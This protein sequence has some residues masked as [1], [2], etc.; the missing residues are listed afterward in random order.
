MVRILLPVAL[1]GSFFSMTFDNA[2]AQQ[3][4]QAQRDAIRT[5]CRSDFI[6]N[7]AGVQP[8]GREAFACLVRNGAKLSAA[9]K[10]AVDGISAPRQV[11]PAR[12]APVAPVAPAPI[13]ASQAAVPTP[14]QEDELK[15]VRQ[16]CSL[17]DFVAHCSW[18]APTSPELLLCLKAN[19]SDLSPACQSVVQSTSAVATPTLAPTAPAEA[20]Q[21][22]AA[23]TPQQDAPAPGG[24]TQPAA[25]SPAKPSP[26]QLSAIRAAC[27][28]DFITNCR[29]VQPGGSAALQCL[30]RNAEQLAAPCR[31][32][33]TA[34][35]SG[36]S[37]QESA[38]V[39]AEKPAKVSLGPMPRMNPREALMILR[40]CGPDRRSV[41]PGV[42]PG[43]GRLISCL[44]ENASLLSPGCYR[45]LSSAARR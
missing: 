44:A 32:A 14:S 31:S 25:A 33:L 23:V 3:P 43:G 27:R 18:I 15:T 24:P 19:V 36:A 7:C 28:S 16:V 1:A 13:S 45:V 37:A 41:C 22:A 6:A 42:E 10:S 34:I 29:G 5:S 9:C 21:P 35:N 26:R 2:T 12:A 17:N 4:T 20:P 30:T 11:T 38:E 39:P 8:G 40:L